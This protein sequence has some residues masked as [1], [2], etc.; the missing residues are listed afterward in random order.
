MWQAVSQLVP[1]TT[2]QGSLRM[3]ALGVAFPFVLFLSNF[4]FSF[5]QVLVTSHSFSERVSHFQSVLQI[6]HQSASHIA[7]IV[8]HPLMIPCSFPD[9]ACIPVCCVLRHPTICRHLTYLVQQIH[10]QCS[11]YGCNKIRLRGPHYSEKDDSMP[12]STLWMW[13]AQ[14]LQSC[15]TFCDPMDCGL[16]GS[17]VHGIFLARSQ[18]Q[19][20]CPSPVDLPDPGIKPASPVLQVDSLPAE[21]SGKPF[22]TTLKNN[23]NL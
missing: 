11:G 5:F 12:L 21:P 23:V 17:S 19:D 3:R 1:L 18:E 6:I 16:P 7:V 13:C 4:C 10:L 14:M 20:A 9:Q 8:L 22:R 2:L 15:V